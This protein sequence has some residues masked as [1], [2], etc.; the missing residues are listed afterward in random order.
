MARRTF[1]AGRST[2]DRRYCHTN[3]LRPC[4]CRT[5]RFII[6]AS[7]LCLSLSSVSLSLSLFSSS[8]LPLSLSLVLPPPLHLSSSRLFCLLSTFSLTY[9]LLFSSYSFACWDPSSLALLHP[10]QPSCRTCFACVTAS[11]NAVLALSPTFFPPSISA[12]LIVPL[13]VSICATTT[14]LLFRFRSLLL[15]S[16]S[17][18]L[19]PYCANHPGF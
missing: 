10:S 13:P 11:I 5:S 2:E 12:P 8:P 1:S 19:P 18:G 14:F 6:H 4:L 3:T 15:H 17:T 7:F 16:S 9:I